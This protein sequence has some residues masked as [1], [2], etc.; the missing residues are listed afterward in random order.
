MGNAVK[1][2]SAMNVNGL[3]TISS[4]QLALY[5]YEKV[6]YFDL[7][8]ETVFCISESKFPLNLK[9]KNQSERKSF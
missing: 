1:L 5:G 4:L 9:I 2:L 6:T 7:A 3:S 8:A